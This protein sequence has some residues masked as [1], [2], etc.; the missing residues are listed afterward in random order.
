MNWLI[1][2]LIVIVLLYLSPKIIRFIWYRRSSYYKITK[3]K[4]SNLNKGEV[5]EYLIWKVLRR[6]ERKGGKFLFNLYIPKP[7]EETTEIDVVLIHPKGFFVFESKNYN[8]WIFGNENNRY[9]TQTL[10]MGRGYESNKEKFY[11]PIRQNGSHIKHLKRILNESVPMWSLIVFSDDCTFKDVTVSSDKRYK[12]LHLNQLKSVVNKLIKD[13]KDD[14]FSDSD[15]QWMYDELLPFTDVSDEVKDFHFLR[16]S[17]KYG[18][19]E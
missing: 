1:I 19:D 6:F 8:G 5:G 13:T 9:W 18:T 14:I 16:T 12:V 15:I 2:G 11:N 17:S 4:Y 7:N 10:P 3:N